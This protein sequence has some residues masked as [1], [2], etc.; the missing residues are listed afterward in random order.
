MSSDTALLGADDPSPIVTVNS[1]GAS[2]FLL[3]GD[4]A[5]NRIP[6]AL[7]DMGL[8]PA[9]RV[10]HIAWDIGIARLGEML[11]AALDA[12]FVRQ[13]YSRLVIDCNRQPDA[14][15]AMP[16]ISDGTPVPANTGLDAAGRA[17]RVAAIHTPY[18]TAIG[19]EI[20]QR[21]AAGQ[22]TILIALHSFTP[23]MRGI[24]RPW[25]IGILHDGG[26]T[27]FARA[28][29]GA[30]G[31]EPDLTV[32]DNEPY[33]MDLIDYT[34]PRHA[35]P[36]RLPYAEIEV[37]QDLIGDEQGCRAWCDRLARLFAVAA[38]AVG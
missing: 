9:E 31:G 27:G 12:V 33:R 17:A 18:Q 7:G 11:S 5:G 37:R 30:L 20:A 13:V 10:R 2:S 15:D 35:Y 36:D 22:P 26:E 24:A 32:G 6:A 29:L 3:I 38:A 14:A 4:H 28:L 1:A 21:R 25:Q 19:V 8:E 16:A 34:I 23:V